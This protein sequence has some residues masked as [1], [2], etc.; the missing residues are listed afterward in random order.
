[1]KRTRRRCRET[2]RSR[3]CSRG[4]HHRCFNFPG[5]PGR[6]MLALSDIFRKLADKCRGLQDTGSLRARSSVCAD[7][8]LQQPTSLA[9]AGDILAGAL[10]PVFC[11]DSDLHQRCRAHTQESGVA[12]FYQRIQPLWFC[13]LGI[14]GVMEFVESHRAQQAL[15]LESAELPNALPSD[16]GHSKRQFRDDYSHSRVPD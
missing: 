14:S 8:A 13:I 12:D 5:Y 4:T 15:V 9:D 3:V 10:D 2:G 6:E 11:S 1:M 16:L 7:G